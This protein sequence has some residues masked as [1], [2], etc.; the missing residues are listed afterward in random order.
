MMDQRPIVLLDILFLL[1][2][3]IC[4]VHSKVTFVFQS[5]VALVWSCLHD[6]WYVS[7]AWLLPFP[8]R[9]LQH[10]N[11]LHNAASNTT[12]ISTTLPPT[13]QPS[14]QRC[15]QH[16][17]H[18]HNAASNTTTISTTLPPTQ[19]PSPQRCLQHNNHPH[20]AASNT[21]TISTTLPPT[22][23]PSPQHCLQHNK[24]SGKLSHLD[25]K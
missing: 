22:Q 14:P 12:T 3:Y 7:A 18:P 13:Q 2:R 23:Q 10:N 20:N 6:L 9:C 15:L 24:R 8:Q 25:L 11:H 16:N 21:T 5:F 17:N 1:V 19:Q 4:H